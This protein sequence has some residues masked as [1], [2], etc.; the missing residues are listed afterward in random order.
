MKR[1]HTKPYVR[2]L[3]KGGHNCQGVPLGLVNYMNLN[4]SKSMPNEP[5][6]HLAD[7][8]SLVSV[9][10]DC[11]SLTLPEPR[12]GSRG[13]FTMYTDTWSRY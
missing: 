6:Q 13:F 3:S 5:I 12:F 9:L 4:R 2:P 11:L 10:W 7:N 1:A 8:G